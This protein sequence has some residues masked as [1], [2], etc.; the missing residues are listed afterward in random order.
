MALR[1]LEEK[2][3]LSRDLG[4]RAEREDRE[5]SAAR[6]TSLADEASAAARLIREMLLAPPTSDEDVG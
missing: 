2:A 5:L 1:S 3:A 4:A 6:F